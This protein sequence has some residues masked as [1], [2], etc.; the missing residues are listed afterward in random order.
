M[1]KSVINMVLFLSYL[2]AGN[3]SPSAVSEGSTSLVS[4]RTADSSSIAEA[5]CQVTLHLCQKND[6][7]C[8]NRY[9]VKDAMMT[10]LL[11]GR[12]SFDQGRLPTVPVG[13]LL[14]GMGDAQDGALLERLACRL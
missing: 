14:I 1:A 12:S 10:V 8:I 2:A 6:R 3:R 9:H 7:R 11:K 5:M 4:Q 13:Q